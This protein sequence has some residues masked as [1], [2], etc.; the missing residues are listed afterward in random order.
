MIT[1]YLRFTKNLKIVASPSTSQKATFANNPSQIE[2]KREYICIASIESEL[3]PQF[4]LTTDS[5]L[6]IILV[7]KKSSHL[8]I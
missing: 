7:L 2:F 3:T 8:K 4:P 6:E 1:D 5:I